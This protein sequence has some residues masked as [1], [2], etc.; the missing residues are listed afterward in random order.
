M[1][2]ASWLDSVAKH[3][4]PAEKETGAIVTLQAAPRFSLEDATASVPQ[5]VPII[6]LQFH[7]LWTPSQDF[8]SRAL[9]AEESRRYL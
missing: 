4:P 8:P 5:R 1:L 7:A 6:T 9:A 2:T 3:H